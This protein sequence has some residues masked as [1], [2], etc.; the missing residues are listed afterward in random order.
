[1]AT[2]V[3][4]NESDRQRVDLSASLGYNG[5]RQL[6]YACGVKVESTKTDLARWLRRELQVRGLTQ[7]EVGVYAGVAQATISDILN[8]G[9]LPKVETLFRLADY[10][11]TP[12]EQI[13]RLAGHLPPSQAEVDLEIEDEPLLRE[14]LAEFRQVPEEWKPIAVEQVAQFRRLAALRPARLI[15]QE[16]EE[17]EEARGEEAG[18]AGQDAARVA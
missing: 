7:S 9:H 15:G 16:E 5:V 8:K 17:E 18:A 6:N 12:R 2:G 13:L 14:L 4:T 10:F 11:Q 1:M 3:G